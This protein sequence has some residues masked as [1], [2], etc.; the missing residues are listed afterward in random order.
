[1]HKLTYFINWRWQIWSGDCDVWERT[2]NR[3]INEGS[4]IDVESFAVS[5]KLEVIGVGYGLE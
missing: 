2:N 5:F 4:M 3:S 1:M